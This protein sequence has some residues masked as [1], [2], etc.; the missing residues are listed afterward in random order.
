MKP[1]KIMV[2]A[3]ALMGAGSALADEYADSVEQ[4]LR[5][6]EAG[7]YTQTSSSS[8]VDAGI[9]KLNMDDQVRIFGRAIRGYLPYNVAVTNNSGVRVYIDD[10]QLQDRAT[11]SATTPGD[12]DAVLMKSGSY[13]SGNKGQFRMSV[14]RDNLIRKSLQSVVVEP[15]ETV[16][17]V[18]FAQEISL[19]EAGGNLLISLQSLER[20]A[21]VEIT[22][23]FAR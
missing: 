8:G 2:A 20:L 5:F 10:I 4:N 17:G 7:F 19:G 1:F 14:L 21:Y 22:V 16:Q 12:L 6:R 13:F 11:Q 18:V 3:A 9:D 15:G 23:P